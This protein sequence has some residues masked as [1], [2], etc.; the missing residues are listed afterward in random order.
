MRQSKNFILYLVIGA[1]GLGVI[2]LGTI[3]IAGYSASKYALSSLAK[4]KEQN[5]NL[6]SRLNETEEVRLRLE[7]ENK[8]LKTMI[9]TLNEFQI[10]DKESFENKNQKTAGELE[11][12]SDGYN[13]L[14]EEYT[15]LQEAYNELLREQLAE[16]EPSQ[17]RRGRELTAE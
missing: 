3:F 5:A 10:L 16:P 15:L 17:Q 1:L 2:S 4:F 7:S 14:K 6:Q 12:R 9:D 11:D 13:A 8:Q